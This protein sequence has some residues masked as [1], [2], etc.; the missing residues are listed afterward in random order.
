MKTRVSLKYFVN[1]SRLRN[2]FLKYR[3]YEN[4]E[5]FCEQRDV[6]PSL[7]RKSKK[8]YFAKLNEKAMYRLIS[9]RRLRPLPL[10]KEVSI[11]T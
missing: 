6:Y 10:V 2:L 5:L 9:G 7:L 1:D 4:R 3:S 8:D 11:F